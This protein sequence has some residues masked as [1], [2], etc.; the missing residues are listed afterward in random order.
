M[1]FWTRNVSK[2]VIWTFSGTPKYILLKTFLGGSGF[3]K[4]N[5]VIHEYYVAFLGFWL[6]RVLRT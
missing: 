3:D 6:K 1:T 2:C 5:C 4:M